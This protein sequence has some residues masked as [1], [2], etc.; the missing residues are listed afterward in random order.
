MPS[1]LQTA[2]VLATLTSLRLT[3]AQDCYY[4]NGDLSPTDAACS[5][6]TGSQCCPYQWDCLSNG[7]CHYF[8]QTDSS[9]FGR[10]TC[11]D[12]TWQSGNCPQICT[13]NNTAPGDEALLQC[14]DGNYITLSG[15]GIWNMARVD[16]KL[17]SS[18]DA[19][20]SSTYTS[21]DTSSPMISSGA[22]STSPGQPTSTSATSTQQT[23]STSGSSL[24]SPTPQSVLST[25]T[26]QSV[27]TGTNGAVSTVTLVS[28]LSPFVPSS[29]GPATPVPASSGKNLP[30]TIGLAVGIPVAILACALIAYLIWRQRKS[31]KEQAYTSPP[32]SND[33]EDAALEE[34]K[35][36]YQVGHVAPDG[37]AP[38]LDS[39]P[40]A[41]RVS[42]RKSEL[43]GSM[44]SVVS[45][46]SPFLPG[47]SPASPGLRAV[48]EEPAELWGGGVG[49]PYVAYKPPVVAEPEESAKTG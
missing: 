25:I 28:T 15:F 16:F 30:L 7:L 47:H 18:L 40:V 17:I 46:D 45:R 9:I 39:Y 26:S 35:Y 21:S 29:A 24:Q 10:Y 5:N 38:E 33:D 34:D 19:S 2:L 48:N 44:H 37:R 49:G 36:G 22:A 20:F 13:Q 41:R 32:R 43:E 12:Q 27:T 4:P 1:A 8:N 23:S 11:T 6:E 3:S 31:T 14:A 42:N